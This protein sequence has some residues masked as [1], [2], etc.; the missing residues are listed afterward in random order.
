MNYWN[1][2]AQRVFRTFLSS[3]GVRRKRLVQRLA[4]IGVETTEAAIA[5]RIH[6][7]TPTL[8]FVLQV[9]TAL[10]LDRIEVGDRGDA[11]ARLRSGRRSKVEESP[12]PLE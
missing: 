1:R 8:A 10:G 11:G 7:G 12:R 2:E 4:D 5:N 3:S 9:A 6:R